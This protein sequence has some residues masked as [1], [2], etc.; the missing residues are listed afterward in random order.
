MTPGD[1]PALT[2]DEWIAGEDR[3][4]ILINLKDGYQAK[5]KE[6][7]VSKAK[8]KANILDRRENRGAA[9]AGDVPSVGSGAEYREPTVIQQVTGVSEEKYNNLLDEFQLL[10]AVLMKHE[11]RIRELEEFSGLNAKRSE[12]AA[13]EK[14]K[15]EAETNNNNNN[16]NAGERQ[17]SS[18]AKPESQDQ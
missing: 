3:E 18:E 10:K 9:A 8:P 15:A 16:T 14:L 6:F 2:A 17:S 13:Q 12:A 5:Q 4:P 1:V 7:T 11:K